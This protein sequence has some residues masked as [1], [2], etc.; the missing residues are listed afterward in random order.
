M[1]IWSQLALGEWFTSHAHTRGKPKLWGRTECGSTS[2]V[3][4]RW[5]LTSNVS[6]VFVVDLAYP[7]VAEGQFPH[8]V[9]ALH[10]HWGAVVCIASRA[11]EAIRGEVV[12]AVP[13]KQM[14]EVCHS[15]R[16]TA[17]FLAGLP[18]SQNSSERSSTSNWHWRAEPG[19]CGNA[20]IQLHCC[21]DTTPFRSHT[22]KPSFTLCLLTPL[23]YRASFPLSPSSSCSNKPQHIFWT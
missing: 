20:D 21:T 17:A 6:F 10:T 12:V 14:C 7:A 4:C 15:S 23:P 16:T 1:K 11:T 13:G 3:Q 5:A 8:P 9:H 2:S 22:T 19:S 18:M